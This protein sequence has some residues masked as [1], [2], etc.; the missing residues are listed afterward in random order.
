V[1]VRTSGNERGALHEAEQVCSGAPAEE[2][3]FAASLDRC[4]VAGFEA[5]RLVSNT[6]NS[7]MNADQRAGVHALSNLVSRH[8]GVEQLLTGHDAMRTAG[9]ASENLFDRAVFGRHWQP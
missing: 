1:P 4:H 5:R 6:E 2:R 8:P 9:E 7:A 3:A